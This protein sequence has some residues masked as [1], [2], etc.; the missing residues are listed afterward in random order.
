MNARTQMI[1]AS[2]NPAATFGRLFLLF[3]GADQIFED[4]G[5][6]TQLDVT[7]K[8]RKCDGNNKEKQTKVI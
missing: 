2:K 8:H 7:I 1:D 6:Q 5:K 4:S 3:K